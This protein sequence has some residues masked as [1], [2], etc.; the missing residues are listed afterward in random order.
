MDK[1]T[2]MTNLN[3]VQ[4][5]VNLYHKY[6]SAD[7]IGEKVTQIEHAIQAA[8]H[9]QAFSECGNK[10]G[11]LSNVVSDIVIPEISIDENTQNSI[12][13]AALLHDI[14]HL[15]Y[16]EDNTITLMGNLGVRNHEELGAFYLSKV[17]FNETVV[18]LVR[19]HVIAKRYLVTRFP[20]YRQSLS[21]ASLLTLQHQGGVLSPEE[22]QKFESHPLYKCAL[23]IRLADD[24]AKLDNSKL[25]D[26]GY[27]KEMMLKCIK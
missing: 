4:A 27:Y 10:W 24:Y 17:G 25:E 16:F 9:A 22:L 23:I 18:Y 13:V 19:S 15:L 6:G 8:I 5:I 3:K 12:I 11:E 21:K 26:I 2:D 7:Y 14:G 1:L 20:K